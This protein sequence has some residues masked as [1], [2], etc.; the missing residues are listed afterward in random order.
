MIARRRRVLGGALAIASLVASS[1]CVRGCTSSRP[2]IHLNPS[3]DNLSLIH[4]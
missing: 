1:G 2:P 3:M 4:I